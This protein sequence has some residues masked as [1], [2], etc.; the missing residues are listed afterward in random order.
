MLK[1]KEWNNK[2]FYGDNLDVMQKHIKEGIVDLCYIDPPFN[3]KRNYNQIY[4][5][6]G[7]ED[8]AQ[9]QAF[10][11]TWKWGERAEEELGII[12]INKFNLLPNQTLELISGLKSVLKRGSLL[13]YLVSMTLRI[14]EIYRV[15]KPT[16][17]FYLHCDPTASHYLKLICDSIFCPRGGDFRNEIIWHYRRWTNV[18]NQFQSMH[19]VILFYTKTEENKFN[20]TEVDMSDSQKKKFI[21]G[22]DSNV[23]HTKKGKYSQLIVYNKAKFE[24]AVQTGKLNPDKFKNIIFRD[25]PLVA[26]SD[27][28]ILPVLNSQAKER[29]GYQ[30]QKPTSLLE[31]IIESSSNK[32]DLVL[33]AYCGCGTTIDVAEKLKRKWI[34]I[35][36]T[37]HSIS[38]IKYRLEKTYGKTIVD[39]VELAGEP[40]DFKSAEALAHKKDDRTRKEFEKWVVLKYSRNKAMIREL[41]GKDDGIDG[42]ASLLDY[43]D[44]TNEQIIK[45]VLFSVKSDKVPKI[46]YI[47]D[48]FG[49]VTR[50]EAA[51][52]YFITLYPP[53]KGMIEECKKYGSYKCN[54]IDRSYPKIQ[55]ITVQQILDGDEIIIPVTH[56]IEVVKTAKF[57]GNGNNYEQLDMFTDNNE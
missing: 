46:S 42:I 33:D 32:G 6:Q 10:T 44:N 36:I 49:V 48:L 17:S 9:S 2:L 51:F 47:R 12:L 45:K 41:K 3:S 23:I 20:F 13:A 37:Y 39:R 14:A 21:R 16:G 27:V 35:D 54:I 30:T 29:L 26:A 53:T 57:N 22:W 56:Q 28:I 1:D 18:Q 5:N 52:G 38:L 15:L 19:D 55:I 50:E 4:L 24:N 11:D 34:G 43:K 31:K 8:K 7:Q 25:K 40:K